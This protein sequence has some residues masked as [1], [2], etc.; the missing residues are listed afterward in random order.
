MRLPPVVVLS[1]ALGDLLA[2]GCGGKIPPAVSAYSAG[3]PARADGQYA[4]LDP[5][6]QKELVL[7]DASLACSV[8]V[9]NKIDESK[10]GACKCTASSGDWLVDCKD[11]LGEHTPKAEPPALEATPAA[12]P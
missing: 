2:S 12:K 11:W 10:S 6:I 8:D 4:T 3:L 7:K 5:L 1:L 9:A